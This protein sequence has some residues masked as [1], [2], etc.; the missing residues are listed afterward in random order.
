MLRP[1]PAHWFEALVAYDDAPAALAAL[2]GTG[3]IELETRPAETLHEPLFELR[4][5]LERY[6]ELA[7]RYRTCW[8]APRAQ[9]AAPP[10]PA[11]EV[12]RR[13]L[14][15]LSMWHATAAP[16]VDTLQALEREV[17]ELE[18]WRELLE[19]LRAHPLDLGLLR[20][21]G[22]VLARRLYLFAAPPVLDPPAGGVVLDLPL[23]GETARLAIA[24]HAAMEAFHRQAVALHGRELAL[25]RWLQGRATD[26]L[27]LLE[28]RLHRA[29]RGIER[30]RGALERVSEAAGLPA[31]LADIERLRWFVEQVP[32]LAGSEHFAWLSGWTAARAN[33]LRAALAAA[34]VRALIRFSEPPQ[35]LVAPLILRNPWWAR[36][37]ELFA[38][39]LGVPGRTEVDPSPLLAVIAPL[40]FGYMF[41]DVGQGAVLLL[42]GLALSKRYPFMRLLIAGGA[43]AV[44]FGFVFGGL[45]SHEHAIAALWF[46]PLDDPLTMLGVP[47]AFGAALIALGQL[48]N[49]LEAY[50]RGALRRWLLTDAGLLA[51]YVAAG[52]GLWRPAGFWLAA[53]GLGWY[54]LGH[55]LAERRAAAVA[56]ALGT[57]LEQAFQLAVNTLSFVRVGAFAL[58]HAGLSAAIVALAAAAGH[59][60][61]AVAVFAV[62]NLVVIVLEALMVAIQVTRLM[63]FE[64]FI[65]FLRGEGR[66]FRPLPAPPST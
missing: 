32:Q 54:L 36:P 51:A 38:R 46:H 17:A 27:A 40:L 45:F 39:A 18:S 6:D 24:P 30:M 8:P 53:A 1:R 28:R 4:P 56:A 29:R 33:T 13:A 25:P 23:R 48:L 66:P 12:L 50:W 26:N 44:A 9:R 10:L 3:A 19:A 37:F 14:G 49:G 16:L 60:L 42:L 58:A 65:R 2:A 43:S 63:L 22:A 5:L 47:L 20:P 41:A 31:A 55:G 7:G 62:G 11:R 52:F 35:D 59:P 21:D 64:F 15:R 34:S 61:A 57:L